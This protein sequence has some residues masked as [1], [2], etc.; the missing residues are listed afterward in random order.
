MILAS[1][2][3]RAG[4][5]G[6][7]TDGYGGTVIAC[8]IPARAY[9]ALSTETDRLAIWYGGQHVE[10]R[11]RSDFEN[12]GDRFDI[13]RA[14]LRYLGAFDLRAEIHCR[15]NVPEQAG[16]AGSTALLSATLAAVLKAM[17]QAYSPYYFA[18]TNRI[19]ELEHLGV[20][21]GYNDAYSTT[22]G[23][24][25]YMDFRGKAYYRTLANEDY[26]TIERLAPFVDRLPFVVAH[27]GVKHHSGAF[28]RP[29][30]DR[31]LEGDRAVVE[32]YKRIAQLALEGKRYLIERDWFAFGRLMNENYEIQESLAPS[33]DV[34]NRMIRAALKSGALG[35]KLAG[36][37]GGGTI[38]ALTLEPD[39]TIAALREAGATEI[40]S[41]APEEA[42]VMVEDVNS[43]VD[44]SLIHCAR[45]NPC[46]VGASRG[47]RLLGDFRMRSSESM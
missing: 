37:G 18:E 2:P 27:S 20:Q 21:C 42:G 40:L 43:E 10:L 7:P 13:V 46:Q 47:Y 35:A 14:V 31:W 5:L 9:V 29:L 23:G 39:V 1:A 34:N 30:S 3:G 38:I 8:A 44:W 11:E 26:A 17:G 32:G 4:I 25:N 16:L 22:F 36:A 41:L 15:T 33:G 45:T 19:I 28:H 24:L 6:N 12:K